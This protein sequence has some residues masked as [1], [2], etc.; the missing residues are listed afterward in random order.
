M[1]IRT[2]GTILHLAAALMAAGC[3]GF[4][5]ETA[6][7]AATVTLKALPRPLSWRNQPKAFQVI[8]DDGL[9][10]TAAT[11]TDLYP[12]DG[13]LNATAPMLLFPADESFVLT[14]QV[15]VDF[16]KEFDGGFLVAWADDQHWTKLL[17]EKSHY[18]PSSV[19]SAVTKGEVDDCVN[20][21]IAGN[22]VWLRV[23]RNGDEMAFYDSL[24]GKS[25]T[26]VRL[27]KFPSKGPL[28]LGFASQAPVSDQCRTVFSHISY[29]PKPPAEFWSGEPAK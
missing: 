18:G 15:K 21:D 26:Y 23:T 14:V 29:K 8:G 27:F 20:G 22:T 4:A 5:S 1:R 6:Q 16:R 25:W 7:P 3:Y 17:F 24:D 10:I 11:G 12:S 19:C 13:K 2:R 28:R 9:A